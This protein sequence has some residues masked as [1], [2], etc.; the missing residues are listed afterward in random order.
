MSQEEIE[1]NIR[2]YYSEKLGARKIADD[3]VFASRIDPDWWMR[4]CRLAWGVYHEKPAFLDR[5]RREFMILGIV[6][7][8]GRQELTEFH[9]RRALLL[10]CPLEALL[11]ALEVTFVG[12]SNRILFDALRVLRRVV[13]EDPDIVSK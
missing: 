2:A 3:L 6:A 8:Q 1:A 10:G 9:I 13:N 11:E 4:Y 12:A 5:I 7:F